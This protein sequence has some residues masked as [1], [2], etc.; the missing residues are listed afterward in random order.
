MMKTDL[1][2]WVDNVTGKE[3]TTY[4]ESAVRTIVKAHN[5]GQRLP[6]QSP[7]NKCLNQAVEQE[8]EAQELGETRFKYGLAYGVAGGVG[9]ALLID[10]VFKKKTK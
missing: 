9:L 10:Y 2:Q 8:L 5:Q 6:K 3:M 7:S 1:K 4:G